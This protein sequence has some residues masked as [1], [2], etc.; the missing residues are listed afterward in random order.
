MCTVVVR[1][2]N[3]TLADIIEYMLLPMVREGLSHA[4]V[5]TYGFTDLV[6]TAMKEKLD[7]F[8]NELAH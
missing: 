6:K 2:S 7:V 3:T 5:D 4:T 1:Y 8:R